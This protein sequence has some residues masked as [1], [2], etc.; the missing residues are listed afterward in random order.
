MRS[1]RILEDLVRAYS[2]SGEEDE[3]ARV[4]VDH[5]EGLGLEAERDEVGNVHAHRPDPPEDAPTVVLLG[6]IDTVPGR[7][8]V[9]H[10]DGVLTGRGTVDAKGPLTAHAL[11]L[12]RLPDDI[13]LDVR[14]VAAVGE[15]TDSQG[16]RHV[17]ET[18][19]PDAFVIAEP[20]G[21]ATVGLGYKGRTVAHLTAE[22]TPTHPGQPGPTAAEQLLDAVELL[23][24]RTGNPDRDVGFDE[25]TL[26]VTD[27][28]T[29]TDA[30][31]EQAHARLDLRYP[32]QSPNL[33][34][35]QPCL[36]DGVEIH[37]D[38]ALPGV[39]ANPRNPLATALRGSLRTHEIEPRTAVKTGTSDWN[40]VQ[41]AWDAPAIAYGPGEAELDHSPHE[42]I[43]LDSVDRAADVLADAL[44][45]AADALVPAPPGTR[46]Y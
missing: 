21:L 23:T 17:R 9:E 39:R 2:P 12:A 44:E 38:E 10:E 15:E 42:R 40:V 11:A 22:A 24:Q 16:A 28:E 4:L 25:L 33:A 37:V 8:P 19:D 45:R 35:V 13:E 43:D 41:D 14:L 7:L 30:R 36:P 32:D 29:Q 31:R 20:T 5:L 46:R 1:R 27:L 3:A 26:R 18:L 34:A 6:H